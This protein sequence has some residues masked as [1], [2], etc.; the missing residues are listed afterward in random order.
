M[1]GWGIWYFITFNTLCL[2]S[3]I[4]HQRAAFS[5][6]GIIPP[7]LRAPY[8]PENYEIKNCDKCKIKD[9]WKPVRA[10]HCTE[11][12]HCI[13]KVSLIKFHKYIYLDGSPLPM[14]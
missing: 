11:C 9:T 2:L 5:D 8:T 12:G 13:F 3:I 14:D 7:G 1:S 4:S 10:H 6:P